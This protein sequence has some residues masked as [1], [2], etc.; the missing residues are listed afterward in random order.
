MHLGQN[1][2]VPCVAMHP[3]HVRLEGTPDPM[4]VVELASGLTI[5]YDWF[6]DPNGRPV[7][8]LHGGG[9]TRHAW[10][11]AG[12]R[13]GDAGYRA[14]AIDLRG[15]GDSMWDPE[16][17]YDHDANA[18]DV[19]DLVDALALTEPVLVGASLGG[20]VSL[21]AVGESMVTAG[22]LVIVDTAPRIEA[23]G[24]DELR[25]FMTAKPEGFASLDEVA[26]AISEYNPHRPRPTNL[27]GLAKNLRQDSAGRYH[28]HWD[29]RFMTG[30]RDPEMFAARERRMEQ[31]ALNVDVATLLVRGG[32]SDLLSEEGASGFLELC[33]HSEYVNIT[34]ATHMVAGDR[35]DRFSDSVV[36]F[37][38]RVAPA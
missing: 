18:A 29:P 8:L 31:C 32:L 22:A 23:A 13:L 33:P 10:R 38:G 28:W 2:E 12:R 11:G 19:V 26:D 7:L 14:I 20:A 4:E 15:H 37:L 3:D 5:A 16:G 36:E 34:G 9:Q 6:G 1:C 17:R 35:N 21:L 30:P 24:V 27:A 25:S